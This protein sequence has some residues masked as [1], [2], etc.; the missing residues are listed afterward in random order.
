MEIWH[1]AIND[2]TQSLEITGVIGIRHRIVVFQHILGSARYCH[3][4]DFS[5]GLMFCSEDGADMFP[6]IRGLSEDCMAL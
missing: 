5:L 1:A 3:H 6:P 4:A 2:V